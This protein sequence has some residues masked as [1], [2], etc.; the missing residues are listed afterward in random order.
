MPDRPPKNQDLHGNAPDN[1]PVALVLID[2][3]ND[4]EFP[5]GDVLLEHALPAAR[6]IKDLK[7]QAKRSHI[8]VI[9][10]NDNFGKWQ[11]DFRQLV[12]HSLGDDV[13]G[14]LL[15]KLLQPDDD[16]YFVLKP[17]NSGFFA[18]TLET[19]LTYLGVK[20][21]ILTGLTTDVCVLFTANDAFMRDYHLHIP[22]DCVAAI[23]TARSQ[24]M[25]DYMR[26]AL[27]ADLTPS[28][29]LDLATLIEDARKTPQA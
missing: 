7:R 29:R 12:E 10:V 11:S 26:D 24:Q 2:V 1:A 25:L 23:D 27:E 5:G 19:L 13:R 17:K 9:Y 18:T 3:I 4:L 21:L 28:V 8:P 14:K 22:A 6:H 20:T 15:T 16:D